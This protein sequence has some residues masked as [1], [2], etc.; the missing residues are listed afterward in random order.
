[1]LQHTTAT[2]KQIKWSHPKDGEFSLPTGLGVG[3]G[4]VTDLPDIIYIA[5]GTNDGNKT[6][7]A[8]TDDAR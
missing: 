3:L 2:G 6:E 7:N 1:M 4:H 5:I 8:V